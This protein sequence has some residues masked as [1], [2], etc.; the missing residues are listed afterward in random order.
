M[1][2]SAAAE[3]GHSAEL[4]FI[5]RVI[6]A[7]C[8][9]AHCLQNKIIPLNIHYLKNVFKATY[10][11]QRW[12]L[13]SFSRVF[14]LLQCGIASKETVM[15]SMPKYVTKKIWHCHGIISSRN[16]QIMLVCIFINSTQSLVQSLKC[17]KKKKKT[18]GLEQRYL[19]LLEQLST[20]TASFSYVTTNDA[21]PSAQIAAACASGPEG[22]FL[23]P[24]QTVLGRKAPYNGLIANVR[25]MWS[26]QT[27][28]LKLFH[29]I[30]LLPWQCHIST[31]LF[32]TVN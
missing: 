24:G 3:E 18:V 11:C 7:V 26:P 17:E 8:L 16:S 31:V 27:K 21:M 30:L 6:I 25:L 20:W 1:H 32:P 10:P 23:T 9:Q 13:L 14:F 19:W 2:P 28:K 29:H 15:K 12:L 5:A 4:L 22:G